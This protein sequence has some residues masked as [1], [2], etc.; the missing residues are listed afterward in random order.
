VAGLFLSR[1][2]RPDLSIMAS[3]SAV[4]PQPQNGV[5]PYS[6]PMKIFFKKSKNLFNL[7]TQISP[8]TDY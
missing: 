7:K 8:L 5:S 6:I 2:I 1:S 3:A 4:A